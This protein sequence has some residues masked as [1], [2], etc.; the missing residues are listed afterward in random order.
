M[1]KTGVEMYNGESGEVE[2]D[3]PDSK[4][5]ERSSNRLFTKYAVQQKSR[6]D[7]H[8]SEKTICHLLQGNRSSKYSFAIL[9]TCI[10]A[11]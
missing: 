2:G 11:R 6:K 8:K 4:E 9:V 10:P 3:P 7:H 5:E 1:M